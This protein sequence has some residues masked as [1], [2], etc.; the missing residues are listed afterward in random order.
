MFIVVAFL[1]VIK[2]EVPD[3][4]LL[5]FGGQTA[6]NCGVEMYR[7][8]KLEEYGV[9]VLGTPVSSIIDTEDRDLFAARL[10]L[11]DH[12]PPFSK[13][14]SKLTFAFTAFKYG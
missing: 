5:S 4:V 1:Q 11:L 2:K 7:S 3:G 9:K 13:R 14:T 10:V 12:P 6:L 8:K